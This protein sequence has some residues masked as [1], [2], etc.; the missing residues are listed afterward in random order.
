MNRAERRRSSKEKGKIKTYNFT[1]EQLQ[2][3]INHMV[4]EEFEK[5]REKLTNDAINQAMILLL[6]L[7]IEVLMD[8]YWPKSY[9]KR[10][11]EFVEH[12]LEYYRRWQND[13]IDME[14]LKADLWEYAGIRLEMEE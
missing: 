3:T 9:Q 13:E 5:R 6:T 4:E 10:I 7:P 2:I 1:E 11:P 12:V 14:D 8:Y